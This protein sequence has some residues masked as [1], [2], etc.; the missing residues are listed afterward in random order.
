VTT[1]A[2]ATT[3]APR[4]L[5]PV[6]GRLLSGTFWLAVRTPLQ[7]LFALWTIP[8]ILQIVSPDMLGAYGFAWGFGFFQFL[9]EFGMSSALQRQVSETWTKGD[10]AGVDRAIA[11]GMN[12][13]AVMALLQAA[14][15]LL[16]AYV[17]LPY[18]R[19][20]G[21]SYRFIVKLLW[22]QACTAPC[23]GISVVIGSVLQAARR[24]DLTPRFELAV[25][26]LR[27]AVLVIG[28]NARFD[29]F[30][31]I[32][33]QTAVQIGLT[34]VPGA[35]V[36]ARELGHWPHF[37]GARMEDYRALMHISFYMFLM[38]L[39]VVLADRVDKTILGFALEAPGPATAAYEV[40]S[41]PF[42]QI[43]QTGWML[44]YF[45]MPAVASL[46]GARDLRSLERVKY[47]GTRLHIGL[48]IPLAMLA[49]IYAAP[50]LTLWVGDRL[51]YDAAN[52]APLLQLFLV[53]T[54]PVL[55]SVPAQMA[56]GMNRIEVIALSSLVGS[57]V[58][59]P[60]SFY[61]TV[62]LGVSGVIWGSVLTTLFS[63]LLVPGV[64]LFRILDIHP[65]T[66]LR[67]TLLAPSA[68]LVA[69]LIGTAAMQMAMP[70]H[71]SP[72]GNTSLPH[73]L[74]VV[75]LVPRGILQAIVGAS[76]ALLRWLPLVIHLAVGCAAYVAGYLATPTGRGDL[77]E[78]VGK[79][80]RRGKY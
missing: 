16:V 38:Q 19:Y 68:G 43:R 80:R 32:V 34:S 40:V 46:I 71:P 77:V 50:F 55:L 1:T 13:Y 28:V 41:K 65:Q 30:T 21:E 67:R 76:M 75:I 8:L 45:V 78:I 35:W 49:Y 22:L 48:L 27:F 31:I 10:R 72:S 6:L 5:P 53:A 26:V 9:F 69:L 4:K 57:L 44:A 60:L 59:L 24:Y 39:S 56:I 62:K 37:R 7:A 14:A 11:C 18:T 12:F 74:P 54:I 79:L 61:L 51:G 52:I 36:M 20:T 29:L 42:A 47:D 15:L 70:L 23:F 58:N 25:V 73:W 64:Y 3:H 66:F 2:A 17:A 33:A 63:N